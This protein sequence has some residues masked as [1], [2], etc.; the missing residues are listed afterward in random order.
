MQNEQDLSSESVNTSTIKNDTGIVVY[1]QKPNKVFIGGECY[2]AP[3]HAKCPSTGYPDRKRWKM[4]SDME[5]LAHTKST[6]LFGR[7]GKHDFPTFDHHFSKSNASFS[8]SDSLNSQYALSSRFSEL[9]PP[10]TS[11]SLSSDEYRLVRFHKSRC[12]FEYA[13][14]SA[15]C[16][17]T[18][19]QQAV[20]YLTNL[21]KD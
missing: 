3:E 15:K 9:V 20:S 6:V 21:S 10:S 18:L 14:S 7:V 17:L 19:K 11:Q 5:L 13:G 8:S 12:F 2:R 16:K 4:L 1:L